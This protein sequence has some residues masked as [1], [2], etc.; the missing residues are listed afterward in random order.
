MIILGA[1]QTGKTT[2]IRMI[3]EKMA[4]VLWLNADEADVRTLLEN[5]SSTRLKGVFGN[6]KVVV[7]DEAQRIEQAGLTLKLIT[8]QIPE[9]QLIVTG[10]S[11]FDLSN[12]V[13][14]P[15]TGRKVE[16]QLFPFSLE[17]LVKHHGLLEEKRMLKHRMV[18]G[19]YPEIVTH[20]GDEQELLT[21]LTES[22]L[23]KDLLM[24]EGLKKPNKLVKL[25]QALALQVGS[26]VSYHELGQTVGLDNQTVEKYIDLLEKAFV[27]F[28]LS[29]LSRN[30]RN[31]I[32]K[33][34]KV[35]FY[36][37]GILNALI[38]QYQTVELRKDIGALWENYLISERFKYLSNYKV[39]C[40]RYFWRTHEQQEIDYV[41]ERDGKF[42][43]FE[44]KWSPKKKGKFAKSFT[45]AYPD[46]ELMVVT[47]ENYESFLLGPI[48]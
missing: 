45:N 7:I 47:P 32:K 18:F 39:H 9:I 44:F 4:D 20:P 33:G 11:A 37:N 12:Q 13:N 25:L 8:D 43:A 24:L 17:E 5:T 16:Y 19:S 34:K 14:E 42:F 30:L 40:H 36:D 15:L 38:A 22:F 2:L 41:E 10:S 26:E 27:V 31:E 1:R 35:Y 48:K 29:A 21:E 3:T 6:H 46:H 23:Y 28:R